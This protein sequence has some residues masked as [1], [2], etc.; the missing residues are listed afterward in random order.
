MRTA[1]AAILALTAGCTST[2][3]IEPRLAGTAVDFKQA[4]TVEVTLSN[5]AFTPSEIKLQAGKP[6]MLKL[7]D[8]A[9]GGHDFTAPAFFA[10]ASVAPDDA[11]KIAR[12]Q[13]ELKGG[14]TASIRLVPTAGEFPVTCTHFGH[15]ALGMTGK[16]IV[17]GAN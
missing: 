12:G 14:E 4:Q 3:A 1:I 8:G 11:A 2:Q 9:S 13:I 5:F 6:Y 15:A 16:I 7:V 17:E 10:V